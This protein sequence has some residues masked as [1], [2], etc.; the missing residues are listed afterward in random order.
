[1]IIK[2]SVLTIDNN[3]TSSIE[4]PAWETSGI[5]L[6]TQA[7]N[8]TSGLP[9]WTDEAGTGVGRLIKYYISPDVKDED[10]SKLLLKDKRFRKS[11]ERAREQMR[12]G[13]LYLSHSDVFGEQ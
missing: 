9:L 8:R 13:S 2:L 5:A 11:I 10:T 4:S 6:G 1:M 7:L 3:G 12:K